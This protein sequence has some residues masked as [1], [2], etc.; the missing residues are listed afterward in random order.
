LL[1]WVGSE[2]SLNPAARQKSDSSPQSEKF[3]HHIGKKAMFLIKSTG[4][5]EGA[6]TPVFWGCSGVLV[7]SNTK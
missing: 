5:C 1:L 6:G 4:L 7:P 3:Y 2:R